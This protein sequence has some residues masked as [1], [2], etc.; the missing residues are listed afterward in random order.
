MR[1][2]LSRAEAVGPSFRELATLEK[3]LDDPVLARPD[4]PLVVILLFLAK[5]L[6]ASRLGSVVFIVMRRSCR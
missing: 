6:L 1:E 5:H 4:A 3:A 2:R